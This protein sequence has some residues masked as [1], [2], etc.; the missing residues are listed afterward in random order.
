MV[1]YSTSGRS[2]GGIYGR[3]TNS[4]FPKCLLLRASHRVY[5]ALNAVLATVSSAFLVSLFVRPKNLKQ[6]RSVLFVNPLDPTSTGKYFSSHPAACPS[7][8]SSSYFI[9]F[10]RLACAKFSSAGTVSSIMMPNACL[11]VSRQLC[12]AFSMLSLSLEGT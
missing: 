8:I 10:L 3:F 2:S 9:F 11:M 12:L 4:Q 7:W 1:I 6:V 5:V